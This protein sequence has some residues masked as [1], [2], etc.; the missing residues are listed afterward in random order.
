MTRYGNDKEFR[1]PYANNCNIKDLVIGSDEIDRTP[2]IKKDEKY[3]CKYAE[4]AKK[5]E[6]S[7]VKECGIVIRLN[8]GEK[9]ESILGAKK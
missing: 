2:I 7:N 6:G 1:C 4:S 8:R 3:S 9:I 5:L